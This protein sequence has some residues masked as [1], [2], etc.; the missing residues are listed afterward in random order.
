MPRPSF[1]ILRTSQ[2]EAP[3][4]PPGLRFAFGRR[5]YC[6]TV[7]GIVDLLKRVRGLSRAFAQVLDLEHGLLKLVA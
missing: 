3:S 1:L 5:A 6:R 4:Y 2:W 7:H